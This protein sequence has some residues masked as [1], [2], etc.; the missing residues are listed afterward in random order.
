MTRLDETQRT[1]GQSKET[2]NGDESRL[3]G[4]DAA[5]P[6]AVSEIIVFLKARAKAKYRG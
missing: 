5:G 4:K 3:S 6:R 1:K 2:R